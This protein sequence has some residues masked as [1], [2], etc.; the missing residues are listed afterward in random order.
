VSKSGQVS[1]DDA[2]SLEQLAERT[3]AGEALTLT[4]GG[5]PV[6]RII[7]LQPRRV[8]CMRGTITVTGD[9]LASTADEWPALE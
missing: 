6:A 1:I 4:T 2:R 3:R 8:G 9:D 5:R 7:P